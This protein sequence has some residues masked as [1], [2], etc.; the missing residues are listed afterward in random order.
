MKTK[1]FFNKILWTCVALLLSLFCVFQSVHIK[2]ANAEEMAV[3]YTDVMTDLQKDENFNPDDYPAK[4]GDY[5]LQVIQIAES[6]NNKLFIYVYEPSNNDL[7]V[8]SNINLSITPRGAMSSK[9]FSLYSLKPL[10]SSGVFCKYLVENFEVCT[11]VLRYYEIASIYRPFVSTID[12][13]PTDDNAKLGMSYKVEQLWTATTY[14]NTVVYSVCHQDTIKVESKHV[15]FIRYLD[16]KMFASFTGTDSHYVAFSTDKPIDKLFEAEITYS[17]QVAYKVKNSNAI[18]ALTGD[19]DSVSQK[20]PTEKILYRETIFSKSNL[21]GDDYEYNRIQTVKE[22]LEKETEEFTDDT[23]MALSDKKWVLRFHESGYLY[24]GTFTTSADS[25]MQNF[26]ETWRWENVSDVGILRLKY[27][28]EG[29]I[30]DL[31]VVDNITKGDKVPDNENWDKYEPTDFDWL[32]EVLAWIVGLGLL[33]FLVVVILNF[34]PWVI[35]LIGKGIAVAFKWMIKAIWFVIS[36]PFK[37]IG[38]LFKRKNK[39]YRK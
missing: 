2:T 17:Y 26:Q 14:N 34:C 31:G 28:Y 18:A 9:D 24:N 21:F 27:E 33:G 39:P 5:S 15:G 19:K 37:L 1:A 29:D 22:F 4:A 10:S 30:Y 13:M 8:A 32:T 23:K 6:V 7:I 16:L 25:P 38:K 36:L 20:I 3:T 12:D 11:D 35:V